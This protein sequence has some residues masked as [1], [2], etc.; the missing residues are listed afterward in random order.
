MIQLNGK[1][2]DSATTAMAHACG[3]GVVDWASLSIE[4]TRNEMK[5]NP[6]KSQ[7]FYNGKLEAFMEVMS[8]GN[9]MKKAFAPLT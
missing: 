7:E 1:T 3:Q 6:S 9:K 2:F 8:F 4:E 5:N